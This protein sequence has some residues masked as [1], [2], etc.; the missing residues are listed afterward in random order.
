MKEIRIQN[1]SLVN[2]DYEIEDILSIDSTK[3][4][5]FKAGQ[6]FK[7]VGI[8]D[9]ETLILDTISTNKTGRDRTRKGI[10]FNIKDNVEFVT[11]YHLNTTPN[12]F[13]VKEKII[14]T[15]RIFDENNKNITIAR[16]GDSGIIKGI[17]KDYLIVE[18]SLKGKFGK[19]EELKTIKFNP[20]ENNFFELYKKE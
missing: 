6:K 1:Y 9:D 14:F 7:I 19:G 16:V 13:K 2:T 5:G 18:L 20:I 17:N 8:K 15:K 10:E 4:K 3:I 12:I 11:I